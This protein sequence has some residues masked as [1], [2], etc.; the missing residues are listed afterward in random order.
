M[1]F[2]CFFSAILIAIATLPFLWRHEPCFYIAFSAS[3]V[4]PPI[5][6][7]RSGWVSISHSLIRH[8]FG[9]I[10]A[11]SRLHSSGRPMVI[12]LLSKT[13]GVTFVQWGIDWRVFG[14][15]LCVLLANSICS[16][17]FNVNWAYVL[18][19]QDR[20]ADPGLPASVTFAA[21]WNLDASRVLWCVFG[22]H[23]FGAPLRPHTR[24]HAPTF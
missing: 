22:F 21:P 17:L 8:T 14:Y 1:T 19:C 9:N 7:D 18:M 12:K 3:D 16:L 24:A 15:P 6:R 5:R 20:P 13:Y 10:R 2:R 4:A 11:P 23:F